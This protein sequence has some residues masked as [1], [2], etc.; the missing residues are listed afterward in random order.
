[1]KNYRPVTLLNCFSSI[2]EKFLNEQLLHFAK[3]SLSL[4]SSLLVEEGGGA[5]PFAEYQPVLANL[6][7]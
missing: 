7:H 3:H 5:V 1:M 2:Y 6:A 4:I